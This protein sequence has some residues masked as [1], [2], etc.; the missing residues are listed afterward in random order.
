MT[1]PGDLLRQRAPRPAHPGNE[2]TEAY[3]AARRTVAASSTRIADEVVSPKGA[4]RP[5]PGGLQLRRTVRAATRSCLGD[6]AHATSCP[7]TCA[8]AQRRP[9][10]FARSDDGR[11][12]L[13]AGAA[14]RA[15]TRLV[16]VNHMSN[17][18]HGE[19][20]E[21]V[22][23][24]A[25]AA[26]CRCC[27][28]L[29]AGSTASGWQ[30]I[31]ATSTPS[32]ATS[33]TGRPDRRAVGPLGVLPR[34]AVRGRRRDDRLRDHGGRT[35]ADRRR[36]RSRH[37][38]DRRGHR[39]EGGHRLAEPLRRDAVEAHECRSTTAVLE[40]LGRPNWMRVFGE[41][42]GKAPY[43]PSRWRGPA[44]D[45]AQILAATGWRCRR[46]PLRGAADAAFRR[47]STAAPHRPI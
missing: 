36:G 11:L 27:R 34:A 44:H 1:A 26:A 42:P 31:A 8:R 29:P 20:V 43:W 3:E 33:F 39:P 13:R 40:R 24:I 15:E 10:R 18:G 47:P 19:P 35:Y 22:V 6:G 5:S 38:A 21:E 17:G 4:P 28:R 7:G 41:A 2:T 46:H 37:A 9:L 32:P 25:P 45:V 12:D 16:S 30:A 23:R 14:D